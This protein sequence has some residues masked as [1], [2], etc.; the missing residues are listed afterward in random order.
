M[1][2]DVMVVAVAV[3]AVAAAVAVIAVA[4]AVV[5]PF[6]VYLDRGFGLGL[7]PRRNSYSPG[8]F[9]DGQQQRC[10]VSPC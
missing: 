4:A 7:G 2:A 8:V 9:A 3:I 6:S 5:L 10:A 1:I